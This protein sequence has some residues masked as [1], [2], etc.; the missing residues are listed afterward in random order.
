MAVIDI[1]TDASYKPKTKKDCFGIGIFAIDY[2]DGEKE[3]KKSSRV[4][5]EAVNKFLKDKYK[6][7]IKSDLTL[8]ELYAISKGLKLINKLS[9]GTDVVQ[10]Y[11]DSLSAVEML[12]D[13]CKVRKKYAGLVKQVKSS[14]INIEKAHNLTINLMHIKSHCGVYG[15]VQADR[16][17]KIHS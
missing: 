9:N 13:I 15:N 6:N 5:F 10:I 4:Q 2:M 1:Y 12:H 7:D 17:A 8:F 16:L 3:Y 11:S 14:I